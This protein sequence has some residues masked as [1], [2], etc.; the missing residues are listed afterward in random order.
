[1]RAVCVETE[2]VQVVGEVGLVVERA[3][4]AEEVLEEGSAFGELLGISFQGVPVN[5]GLRF[6]RQKITIL[7]I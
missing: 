5:P 7:K 1:M 2:V 3:A 6:S 4:G